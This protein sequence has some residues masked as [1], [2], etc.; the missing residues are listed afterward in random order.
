[1]AE[2][3]LR[4]CDV[5]GVK[6]GRCDVRQ[7]IVEVREKGVTIPIWQGE[8]DLSRRARG[9]LAR[10]IE[11]GLSKPGGEEEAAPEAQTAESDGATG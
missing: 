11:R 5:F 6:D 2:K 1:M 4:I 3:V 9:R 8:G 7:I 10:F